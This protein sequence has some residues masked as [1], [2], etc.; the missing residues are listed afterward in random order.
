M[1]HARHTNDRVQLYLLGG[2]GL[3]L[4]GV[5]V[6]DSAWRLRNSQTLIK[7]LA[8]APGLRVRRDRVLELLWPDLDPD[9]A[10]NNF[11]RTIHFA[12][13]VLIEGSSGAAAAMIGLRRG[14]VS[15]E[16]EEG[17]WVDVLA[18]EAA[19]SEALHRGSIEHFEL[20]A[21]LY[22]GDLLP[23]DQ[24]AV[25]AR[26]RRTVLRETHLVL[27]LEMARRY[28]SRDALAPA[29]EALLSILELEASH[30]DAHAS[31]MRIHARLGRRYQALRQYRRLV[32]ALDRDLDTSPSPATE[33]LRRDIEAGRIPMDA[34][35][36]VIESDGEDTST[37]PEWQSPA[38]T[39]GPIGTR[40]RSAST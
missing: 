12:R 19:A 25:W 33:R 6:D 14:I 24:L 37:D 17:I 38:G 3:V 36:P 39:G 18:Y 35:E 34:P 26:N 2:F 15:L 22:R 10:A 8:L 28:Q 13:N 1:K 30:E 16:P 20:A 11:H 29:Q 7:L 5:P 23:R 4:D 40:D 27:L 21:Q 9:A 31:L 32:E